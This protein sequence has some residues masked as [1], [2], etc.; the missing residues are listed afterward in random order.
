M[1]KVHPSTL[2]HRVYDALKGERDGLTFSKLA[3]AAKMTPQQLSSI[4][5][6]LQSSNAIRVDRRT[7]RWVR[8]SP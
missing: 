5:P 8:I 1:A 3:V 4:L 7:K 6:S 2:W